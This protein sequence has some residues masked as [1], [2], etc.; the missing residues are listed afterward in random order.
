MI[1]VSNTGQPEHAN[2]GRRIEG[3]ASGTPGSSSGGG[4]AKSLALLKVAVYIFV[5]FS[6]TILINQPL[7]R[8]PLTYAYQHM[9]L[10][11][12][13]LLVSGTELTIALS[14]LFLFSRFIDKRPFLSY[15]FAGRTVSGAA[16]EFGCGAAVA[17][18]M[19]SIV[20]LV[21]YMAGCYHVLSVQFNS[22]LFSFLPF[23]FVAA[24]REEVMFR[25]YVMQTLEKNWGIVSAIILSSVMFGFLHLMNFEDD[26]SLPAKLYS[27]FCLSIDAGLVFG[28]AYLATRRLW[29]PFGLHFA[30]NV[31][32]GPIYGTPVSSLDLAKPLLVSKLSG[33]FYLTGGVFG[34]EASLVE[35]TVCLLL[36]GIMWTKYKKGARID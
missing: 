30:W 2:D 11:L 22:Q 20:M 3:D 32:E 28:V 21:L 4:A 19:V 36:V 25:G 7:F 12:Y 18:L 1:K 17:A 29:F 23:F 27:C 34:P 26:V 10:E 9:P 14:M 16:R 15:G 35:V 8:E 5:C 33:P 31:F 6:P 24:L 13:G